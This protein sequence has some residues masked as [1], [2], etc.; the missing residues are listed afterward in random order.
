MKDGDGRKDLQPAL[1]DTRASDKH[2]EG[3]RRNPAPGSPCGYRFVQQQLWKN[4]RVHYSIA[5]MTETPAS[6]VPDGKRRF[7]VLHAGPI[8]SP[9]DTVR[10]AIA[11]ESN[12][13]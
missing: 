9:R 1:C 12:A 7:G 3:Y 10:A 4:R 5:N 13:T 11:A 8:T 2:E 6:F